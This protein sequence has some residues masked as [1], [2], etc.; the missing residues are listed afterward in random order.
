MNKFYWSFI[1][2]TF[3]I[4]LT[5][6]PAADAQNLEDKN[7]FLIFNPN[8]GGVFSKPKNYKLENNLEDAD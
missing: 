4:A 6:A 7:Q 8:E 3:V 1:L 5:F 2:K